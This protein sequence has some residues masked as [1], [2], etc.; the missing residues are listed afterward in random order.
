MHYLEGPRPR[1]FA[2]AGASGVAPENTMTAFEEAIAAGADRLELDVHASAD[3]E[4]VV[5]H[6]PTVDRTTGGSGPVARLKLA[7]IR[8]LD[9][10]YHFTAPD[11]S[12][13]F[14]GRGIRV[15]ALEEVLSAFPGVPLNI[16]IKVFDPDLIGAVQ[17][18]LEK[19]SAMDR[20]LLAAESGELM[21][22]I[23][24][25]IKGAI[26]GMSV[27][28]VLDFLMNAGSPGYQPRGVALQVPR[29]HA[30]NALVTP[31]FIHA[32]HASGLEVH[33]WV[34][35]NETEMEELLDLGVDGI[36]TDFPAMGAAV[37]KRRGLRPA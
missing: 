36:M 14:R 31:Q 2:H 15:P 3:G 35:N 17:R 1:L 37:W 26:T 30:G 27:A 34:I 8:E 28:D 9:A 11:G 10:G 7:E 16:E 20:A 18:L 33:V 25:R 19:F 5:I 21:E 4:V 12:H 23:R 32:A 24:A 29:E 13:P 6:D 22:A